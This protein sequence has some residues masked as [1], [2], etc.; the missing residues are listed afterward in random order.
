MHG[1][2]RSIIALCTTLLIGPALG[3]QT[4]FTLDDSGSFV[5]SDAPRPGTDEALIAEARRLLALDQPAEAKALLD[6]WINDF[7]RTDNA[8]LPE[9]YLLRGDAKVA[10]KDEYDALFDYEVVIREFSDS[11]VF[12]RAVEREMEIGTRYIRGMRRKIFGLRIEPARTLGEELLIRAQERMPSSAIGEEAAIRLADHYFARRDM[13]MAA[14]MYDIFLENY[15]ES[16]R[17]KHARINQIYAHIGQ[18]KGPKYDASGLTDAKLLI[19]RFKRRYP[20][21]AEAAG[22]TEGLET[23]I[24][25]SAARQYLETARWYMQRNDEASAQFTLRRLLRKHPRSAAAQ[26]AI[27]VM[28]ERG[29]IESVDAGAGAAPDAIGEQP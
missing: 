13:K 26:V 25:E 2:R 27:E 10:L 28:S 5:E 19:E 18:F 12:P 15:P 24:D 1:A 22:I 3:Q 7:E 21:E 20:A 29:W 23:R 8:W 14:E 17:A 6:D 9:A 16:D 4:E 11:D